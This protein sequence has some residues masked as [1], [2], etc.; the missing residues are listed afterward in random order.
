MCN[1][2]IMYYTWRTENLRIQYCFRDSNKFKWDQYLKNIPKTASSLEGVHLM[3]PP[4]QE[5]RGHEHLE[6]NHEKLREEKNEKLRD[7]MK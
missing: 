7:D 4:E 3:I 5:H 2:Y 1:F 6:R